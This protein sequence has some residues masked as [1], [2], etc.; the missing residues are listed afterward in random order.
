MSDFMCSTVHCDH[1]KYFTLN[2]I[3]IVSTTFRRWLWGRGGGGG[4]R[5]GGWGWVLADGGEGGG[6]AAGQLGYPPLRALG[7]GADSGGRGTGSLPAVLK[8]EL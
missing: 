1:L 5:D 2:I 6:V 7:G 8:G 4:Q 3:G